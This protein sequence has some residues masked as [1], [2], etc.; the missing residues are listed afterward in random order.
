MPSL[1]GKPQKLA[2][3]NIIAFGITAKK[4]CPNHGTGAMDICSTCFA[5]KGFYA[6]PSVRAAYAWRGKVTQDPNFDVIVNY[7]LSKLKERPKYFRIH[8]SGDFYSDTY[9]NKWY[10]IVRDN[11]DI[12][13]YCYTKE[14]KRF[15]YYYGTELQYLPKNWTVC[16]SY[17]GKQDHLIDPDKHLHS[18]AFPSIEHLE[19]CGYA[20]ATKDDL[21]MIKSDNHR[22]GLVEH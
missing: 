15:L 1:F 14:V 22:I 2:K 9:L 5:D 20:D 8:D 19:A 12:Q 17:G 11:P 10:N 13:F 7:E 18:F 6:M 21:T 16:F 4:Y 3:D